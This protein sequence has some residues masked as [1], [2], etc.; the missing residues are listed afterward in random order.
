MT[1]NSTIGTPGLC[2]QV[3]NDMVGIPEGSYSAGA[4]GNVTLHLSG[5]FGN[6]LLHTGD[7]PAVGD[8]LYWDNTDGYL[9][10][11][12]GGNVLAGH[13]YELPAV[14]NGN[15]VVGILLKNF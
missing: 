5:A 2:I 9:T 11:T 14:V 3:G 10:T 13:C 15:T 12:S 4:V 8:K 7:T 1:P 6:M